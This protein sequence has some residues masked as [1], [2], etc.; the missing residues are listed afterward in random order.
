MALAVVIVIGWSPT[1]ILA[2]DWQVRRSNS[3]GTCSIQR[4][5]SQP[6]LGKLLSTKPTKKEACQECRSLKT[7]DPGDSKKCFDY[8]P[9]TADVCHAEGVD[10]PK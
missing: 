4:S 3:S 8:T 6:P 5:D 7:E 10:L 9:N 1:A 2:A